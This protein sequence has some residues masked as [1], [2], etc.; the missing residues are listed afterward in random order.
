MAAPTKQ[1]VAYIDWMRGLAC[2]GDV[3]DALL[4]LLARRRRAQDAI[5]RAGRSSAA[6]FPRRCFFFSPASPLRWLPIAVGS[7]E[8]PPAASRA[9]RC[10]AARGIRLRAPVPRAGISAG[11]ALGAVD[12]PAPRG[13]PEHHRSIDRISGRVDRSGFLA[14]HARR[15]AARRESR[16]RSLPL[17]AQ[18]FGFA[19]LLAALGIAL[20]TPP[21]WTTH[22][23]RWLPWYL[24][25]YVNGVHIFDKPQSWLFPFISVGG[26]CLRRTWRSASFC[27]LPGDAATS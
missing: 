18:R 26:I 9:P 25:S 5:L 23:P 19:A 22:R 3:S 14:R 17:S 6:R 21:L 10:C 15:A 24:E 16:L 20:V 8:L 7:R 2:R 12:R 1:R 13:R 4:R 27:S 11:S